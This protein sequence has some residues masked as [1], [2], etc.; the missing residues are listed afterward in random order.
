MQFRFCMPIFLSQS[1]LFISPVSFFS[2][3]G[4]GFDKNSSRLH[5]TSLSSFNKV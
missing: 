4:N 1:G 5:G 2:L 3:G